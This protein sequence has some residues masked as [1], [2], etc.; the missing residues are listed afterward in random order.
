MRLTVGAGYVL[1]ILM[2]IRRFVARRVVR[3]FLIV[4]V[5]LVGVNIITVCIKIII[6][7]L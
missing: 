4:L 3:V 7:S 2:M 6:V 5:V 1:I